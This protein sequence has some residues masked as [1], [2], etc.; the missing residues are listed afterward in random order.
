[1]ALVGTVVLAGC[2]SE[3]AEEEAREWTRVPVTYDAAAQGTPADGG[4]PDPGEAA[5]AT[6]VTVDMAEMY[7]EPAE[8]SI[9]AGTEVT[10]NLTNSGV[11]I[12][13]FTVEALGIN[14][15]LDPGGETSITVT[16]DAGD[17]DYICTQP[18]HKEAGMV[19]VMSVLEEGAEAAE[20][21]AS[22][23]ASPGASPGASPVATPAGEEAAEDEDAA[24]EL[25]VDMAEMFF[26]PTEFSIPA[27]TDVTIRLTNSGVS[28]HDFTIEELGINE[29][30]DPGA[31]TTITINAEAGTYDYICTQPGHKEAG[32]VGVMT[33]Q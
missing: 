11:A 10:I 7:F 15:V 3:A 17:Y 24:T 22:P 16:A 25:T 32:M 28:P 9:P 6:E 5:A 26:E 4:E 18:G 20:G 29:V 21:G 8:F 12:H 14:E 19:G 31:E 13:D 1:M 23:V 2:G 33:V 30:L 27:G